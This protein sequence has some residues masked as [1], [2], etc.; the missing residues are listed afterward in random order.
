MN[1]SIP[2]NY[3]LIGSMPSLEVFR[4]TLPDLIKKFKANSE[5]ARASRES[6][7]SETDLDFFNRVLRTTNVADQVTLGVTIELCAQHFYGIDTLACFSI[8]EVL[9]AIESVDQD[10]ETN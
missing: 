8:A 9:D 1:T 4:S 3:E 5:L 10:L 2:M 7:S 6:L